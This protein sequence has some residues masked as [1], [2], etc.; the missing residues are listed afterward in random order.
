VRALLIHLK[1]HKHEGDFQMIFEYLKLIP[2]FQ[3]WK[4]G[5]PNDQKDDWQSY[6]AYIGRIDTAICLLDILWP[7]FVQKEGLF[8]RRSALP[9]DWEQFIQQ[10]QRANWSP[11]EIEYVINHVHITDLFLNDPDRDQIDPRVFRFLAEEI[12]SMWKCKLNLL[13]PTE[14]FIVEAKTEQDESEVY[15]CKQRED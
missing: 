6:W 11:S 8:L 1:F 5:V 4:N 14:Q 2:A 3:R 9:Y 12:A 7:E 10:A 13:F 15:V